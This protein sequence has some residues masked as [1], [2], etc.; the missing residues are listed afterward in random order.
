MVLITWEIPRVLSTVSWKPGWRLHIFVTINHNITINKFHQFCLQNTPR[1]SH[2]SLPPP[3]WSKSLWALA[4]SM[5]Y[6]L[7][8]SLTPHL[9]LHPMVKI[10]D[11]MV[12][13]KSGHASPLLWNFKG[14]A[15]YSNRNP[16]CHGGLRIPYKLPL[17]AP[18]P[19]PF[20][21]YYLLSGS[22]LLPATLASLMLLQQSTSGSSLPW[23]LFPRVHT[24]RLL[25]LQIT[26]FLQS[27][28]RC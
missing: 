5:Q 6:S 23:L 19:S 8:A 24:A 22:P 27:V 7:L 12:L 20:T 4:W 28:L 1:S 14:Y 13:L 17:Q 3:S 26:H 25:A 18:V 16:S 21:F 9:A 10:E 2:G 11:G 15:S